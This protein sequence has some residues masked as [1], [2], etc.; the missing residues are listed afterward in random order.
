MKLEYS[1]D[2]G[3]SWTT[4]SERVSNTGRFFWRTPNFTSHNY[5]LRISDADNLTSSHMSLGNISLAEPENQHKTPNWVDMKKALLETTA[6]GSD[7]YDLNHDGQV[8]L[9][10]FLIFIDSNDDKNSDDKSQLIDDV[11]VDVAQVQVVKL[12]SCVQVGQRSQMVL[13]TTCT[14]T[15]THHMQ[16]NISGLLTHQHQE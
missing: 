8:N 5:R 4:I 12:W 1:T 15:A 2:S 10:D 7:M 14:A 9:F 3:Q 6:G 16:A 13:V 11:K